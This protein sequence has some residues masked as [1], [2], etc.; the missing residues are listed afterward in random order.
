MPPGFQE[1]S[2]SSGAE[3]PVEHELGESHA[4]SSGQEQKGLARAQNGEGVPK[5]ELSRYERTKRHRA[6]V[7]ARE[8]ALHQREEQFAQMERARL[9]REQK[10]KRDYTLADL[11][12]YRQAWEQEGNYDLVERADAE[13]KAMEE[14]ERAS[15]QIVELP[16]LGTDQHMAQWQ[17]AEADLQKSDPDFMRSGTALDTKLREIMGSADGDIYRQHPR[18]II[19]AYHR[20]KLE[21]SEATVKE[22]RTELAKVTEENKRLTGLTS[23]GGGVPGRMGNGN[24][25]ESISDFRKLSTADMR[26]HLLQ[27]STDRP[28]GTPWF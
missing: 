3:R 15:K 27:G 11:K 14:E 13:I 26:K 9:A 17:Q 24:R 21:L 6:E 28:G 8:A 7:A 4:E 5:K 20:A 10:P 18:G 12:R 25:V 19:A 1:P 16:R 23:V 22:L 2:E